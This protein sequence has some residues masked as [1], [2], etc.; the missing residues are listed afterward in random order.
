MGQTLYI[1]LPAQAQTTGSQVEIR[2]RLSLRDESLQPY[3]Y[4]DSTLLVINPTALNGSGGAPNHKWYP[5]P[6]LDTPQTLYTD[7]AVQTPARVLAPGQH[8]FLA[9]GRHLRIWLWQREKTAIQSP[10]FIAVG[11]FDANNAEALWRELSLTQ[12]AREQAAL[13]LLQERL[14]PLELF[15]QRLDKPPLSLAEKRSL[16]TLGEAP[17]HPLIDPTHPHAVFAAA[18]FDLMHRAAF[19]RFQ[20][21]LAAQVFMWN[22]VTSYQP[23]WLRRRIADSLFAERPT[24]PLV[25]AI[26]SKHYRSNMP[27]AWPDSLQQA[28]DSLALYYARS[29]KVPR[30]E[31][32]YGFKEGSLELYTSI[33]PA[34]QVPFS[35]SIYLKDTLWEGYALFNQKPD[36]LRI[37]LGESPSNVR[38]STASAPVKLV[39]HKPDVYWL[40]TL[41]SSSSPAEKSEALAALFETRNLNLLATVI[42]IALDEPLPALREIALKEYP[43]LLASGKE[44]LQS[45]LQHLAQNEPEP[46]LRKLAQELLAK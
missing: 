3:L 17:R 16:L 8:T 19:M 20:D 1:K 18:D 4:S 41:Q 31:I 46:H 15:L 37:Y 44:R 32:R 43:R 24:H 25:A 33:T 11:T 36:T 23:E 5:V 10:F 22:L 14:K 6:I 45:T 2:Y 34:V 39:D 7:V 35:Y 28:G 21:T 26:Y 12:E 27:Q 42:G 40:A 30:L 29:L 38:L 9:S 13:A